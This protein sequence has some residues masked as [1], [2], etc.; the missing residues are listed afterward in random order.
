[1]TKREYLVPVYWRE[2]VSCTGSIFVEAESPEDAIRLAAKGEG[3]RCENEEYPEGTTAGPFY[4]A[5]SNGVEYA[6][7]EGETPS[8]PAVLPPDP[9]GRND[10]RAT[11]ARAA[12]HAFMEATGSDFCD[13]QADLLC[14]LMHLSDR[15]VDIN[16][17]ADLLRA[18]THYEAETTEGGEQ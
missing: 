17:E 1:M 14:D 4:D 11:W 9:D 12:I 8:T 7:V 5:D 18:R 2:E 3:Q 10:D 13:A 6:E 15:S 16:F